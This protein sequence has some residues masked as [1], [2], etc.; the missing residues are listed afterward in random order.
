MAWKLGV[1]VAWFARSGDGLAQVVFMVERSGA[2]LK[3]Y[4]G[5]SITLD[6]PRK[7]LLLVAWLF[8]ENARRKWL[9]HGDSTFL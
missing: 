3:C 2:A 7:R 9:K 6:V 5:I 4:S 1:E 8:Y